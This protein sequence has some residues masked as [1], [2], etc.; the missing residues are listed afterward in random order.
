MKECDTSAEA[1][2]GWCGTIGIRTYQRVVFRRHADCDE[3]VPQHGVHA[4]YPGGGDSSAALLGTRTPR[5][6]AKC[7]ECAL[8]GQGKKNT[9]M[10]V[11]D[12]AVY[13]RLGAQISTMRG[14]VADAHQFQARRPDASVPNQR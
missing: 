14:V 6:P 1:C 7:V 3:G 2:V 4:A 13:R 12:V 11:A 5:W 9:A 10:N 8:P